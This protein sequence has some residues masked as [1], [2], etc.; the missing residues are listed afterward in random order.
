MDGAI[1]AALCNCFR[2]TEKHVAY[3]VET[4]PEVVQLLRSA[5]INIAADRVSPDVEVQRKLK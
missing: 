3:E 2:R 5:H 4:V 1:A